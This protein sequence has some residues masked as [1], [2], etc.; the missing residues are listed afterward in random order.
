METRL[1]F[2]SWPSSSSRKYFSCPSVALRFVAI[3]EKLPPALRPPPQATASL[4]LKL[5]QVVMSP[6]SLFFHV[7]SLYEKHFPTSHWSYFQKEMAFVPKGGL[8][9]GSTME[10]QSSLRE[11]GHRVRG[12]IKGAPSIFFLL[13]RDKR[14]RL[15]PKQGEGSKAELEGAKSDRQEGRRLRGNSQARPRQRSGGGFQGLAAPTLSV[16]SSP[17]TLCK[18][19]DSELLEQ[20]SKRPSRR[21]RKPAMSRQAG[22]HFLASKSHP[23]LSSLTCLASACLDPRFSH[24]TDRPGTDDG[25]RALR[26]SVPSAPP[27]A[28]CSTAGHAP[29][30]RPQQ[31]LT[32]P[33]HARRGFKPFGSYV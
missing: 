25:S 21:P 12:R 23:K 20:G 33:F 8:S 15:S 14:P 32:C 2:S 30:Q 18:E 29:P 5:L 6:L 19:I 22:T 28:T 13:M 16:H 11:G 3:N 10:G 17:A 31:D 24:L 27:A 4:S 1:L 9:K 7:F 26:P